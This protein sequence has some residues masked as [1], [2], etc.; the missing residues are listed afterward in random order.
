VIVVDASALILAVADTTARGA[1]A[2]SLLVDG[3]AAPHLVDAEVGQGLRGLVLR[4]VLAP[5]VAERALDVAQQ[6]V[7]D[8]YP[9]APLRP[10][11]WRLRHRVSF[12]G[13]LYVALARLLE[14]P[15]VTA[16][17]RLAS[18]VTEECGLDLV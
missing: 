8:R 12:Y 10:Q 15:L 17:A 6:L 3:S 9:H 16:D 13:G 2:R 4:G 7:V 5:Q 18:T 14:L 1:R 11:A